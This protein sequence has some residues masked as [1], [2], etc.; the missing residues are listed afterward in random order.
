MAFPEILNPG[1]PLDSDAA[2]T[3]GSQARSLKQLLADVLGIPVAPTQ[4]TAAAF[5]ITP[6]GGVTVVQPGLTLAADPTSAFHA[7]TKEYVDNAANSGVG[8]GIATGSANT[9]ALTLTPVP[10][11]LASLTGRVLLIKITATNTGAATL[12]VNGLGAIAINGP[13]GALTGGELVNAEIYAMI[14]DGTVFN[15]MWGVAAL[16]N[17]N[18]VWVTKTDPPIKMFSR[19]AISGGSVPTSQTTLGSINL[20]MPTVGGPWRADVRYGI[21]CHGSNAL[22]TWVND[23]TNSFAAAGIPTAAM[24]STAGLTILR[25][26]EFSQQTYANA[27]SVTWTLLAQSAG[28][29]NTVDGTSD[30]GSAQSFLSVAIMATN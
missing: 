6:G 15:L 11:S 21:G 28:G 25:A 22:Q 18:G 2:S 17:Q 5:A 16:V 23:G 26:A 20:T 1:S 4:I 3:L 29:S 8:Y 30:L 19:T 14:Y 27:A 7:A 12:N 10:P 9:I 24:G 13:A